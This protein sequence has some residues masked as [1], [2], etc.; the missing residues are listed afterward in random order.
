MHSLLSKILNKR[1]IG[2]AEN[3]SKDE[4]VTFENYSKILSKEELTMDDLRKFLSSQVGVI[5]G[6]WRD[7]TL[8]QVKKAEMI[9]YH[10]VYR[11][12]LEA[13]DSPKLARE[14][15]EMQLEQLLK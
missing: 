13:I 5:E 11:T 15:L 4:R 14:S 12:L 3:L 1:G 8:E 2:S 10:V 9:P 6:K 7:L